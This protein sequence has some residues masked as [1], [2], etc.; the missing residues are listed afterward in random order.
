MYH[1]TDGPWIYSRNWLLIL[2]PHVR[3]SNE[4]DKPGGPAWDV[5]E[6]RDCHEI[7]THLKTFAAFEIDPKKELD[8]T[9]VRIPLRTPEQSRTSKI[10][11]EEIGSDRIRKA[12][13]DFGQDVQKGGLLFLKHIR[14]IVIR[15]NTTVLLTAQIADDGSDDYK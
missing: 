12:L 8:G 9:V 14:K 3:W 2:D 4:T 7:K 5:I 1:W 15:V 10:A 13:E 11:T 6:N